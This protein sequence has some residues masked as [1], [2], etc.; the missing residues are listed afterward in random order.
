VDILFKDDGTVFLLF[1]VYFLPDNKA[2]GPKKTV[3][4]MNLALEEGGYEK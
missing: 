1:G 2:N 4:R 3:C